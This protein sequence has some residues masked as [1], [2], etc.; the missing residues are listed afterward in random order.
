MGEEVDLDR[1]RDHCF[2]IW[3]ESIFYNRLL[4]QTAPDM[5]TS[6]LHQQIPSLLSL[7]SLNDK[8]C[9]QKPRNTSKHSCIASVTQNVKTQYKHDVILNYTLT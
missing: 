7:T 1:F 3:L 9:S 5:L 8:D 6:V 4:Q 2:N